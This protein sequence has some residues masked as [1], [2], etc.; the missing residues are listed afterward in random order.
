MSDSE[1]STVTYTVVSSPFGGLL[2][3][4]SLGVDGLPMMLEDPYMEAALQAPP[5]PNYVSGPE[6][7]P[8]PE[9]VHELVYPEF[10]PPEDEVFP[11]EEQPLHAAVSPTVDSPG[12]IVDSDPEEDEEDPEKD[13][14]NYL[15][16]GGDDDNNDDE[17]SDDDED[18][19]DDVV[20]EDED[21]EEEEEHPASADSVPP[22]VHYAEIARLLV[23]PSPPP[24]PL[25]SWSSPLPQIPSPPLLVSSPVPVSPPP[26]PASP[27]YP[28]GYR[29][30]VIRQRAES[31]STSHLL[32]LPP[33]IILTHTRA[34]VAMMRA[35]TPSTY[36]LASQSE[37]PPLSTPPSGIPLL[38]PIPTPTSSPSLLLPSA[39]H[40]AIG[41]RPTGG[42]KV[43]YG[44]VAT[45]YREIRRDPERYV[46]FRILD[47]WDEMLEDMPGVPATDE[48][49]LGQR[50]TDFVT[51]VRQDTDEIYVRLDDAQDE[52]SLMSG[53]LNM[54]FRDRR[55]HAHTTLLIEIKARLS[56]KPW[57]RSMDASDTARSE[58][59]AP[60]GTTRANPVDTT[61][62][63]SM[64]NAQLKAM[65][66]QSVTVALATHDAD[67][68]LNGNDSHNSEMGVRRN[69]ISN[70]SVE[71]QIN[72]S[73]CTLLGS[74][75]M[76]WNSHVRTVGHDVAY[77]MTW[78]DLKKKMTNKYCPR[79]EIKKLMAEL[80]FPKESDKIKRYVSGFPDMIHRSV[81]ASK[82]KT[83]QEAIEIATELMDKKI[84]T[85]AERQR[86]TL[87]DLV[88]RSHTRDLNPYVLNAIITTMVHVLPNATSEIELAIWL[89]T[90]GV[91]QI[92][93]L[94]RIRG[95]LGQVR[96][97]LAMN[98]EPKD[99]SRGIFQS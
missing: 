99:I 23:I 21:E 28:L 47:T 18:D 64:T 63:T 80:M 29:A 79:I 72:F 35:A 36:I 65:I 78:A 33:P 81:V 11:A 85:F 90:V 70:C 68:S 20:E 5:S 71:N 82:P 61:T 94:V 49:E 39:N 92:L 98:L 86:L 83:M 93:M 13:P 41:L 14:I 2:D 58:N 96:N 66:D 62:T 37:T 77:A 59:M 34:F 48:T 45:L 60:K 15:T 40:G 31:P 4:G 75:L 67:R 32:P 76:W 27:T 42:F 24:S 9:F 46:G 95:A 10:M 51:T 8:L 43:D 19:D 73:T 50:I 12:Y 3:I 1:G 26:L 44:F 30:V 88:R 74:A 55:A 54:L 6:Y 87:R 22:P 91:L 56:C 16:D 52:R 97:P 38:L 7:P 84:Y 69:D 89:A 53:Q 17:S 57:R 25:S